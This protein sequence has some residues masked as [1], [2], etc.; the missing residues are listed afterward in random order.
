MRAD[1]NAIARLQS[2]MIRNP[3][4]VDENAIARAGILHPNSAIM[5][6]NPGMLA[7]NAGVV[8]TDLVPR[9]APEP[10]SLRGHD[11]ALADQA[12]FHANQYGHRIHSAG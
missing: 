4:A 12:A 8:E 7:G 5:K 9:L 2:A 3:L 6:D 10:Q 11:K 1:G